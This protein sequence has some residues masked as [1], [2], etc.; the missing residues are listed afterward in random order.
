MADDLKLYLFGDQTYDIQP[1]LKDL[2]RHR[3]NPVLEDFLAKAYDAVRA[4][5]Y[6]LPVQVRD[7]LPRFTCM[8]DLVLWNQ[9]GRRCVPLD[10]AVT[11]MYQ[12][13]HFINQANDVS[14]AA[15]KSR[16]AGLC[17]GALAA[18]AVSCSRNILDL[19]PMAVDAVTVAFRVGMHVTD[20]ALRVAPLSETD[21]SWSIIVP[22]ASSHEAVHKFS[23][24]SILP[25]TSK[26]YVSAYAPN[27]I[28]V[29]GPP[30]TLA[31]LVKSESFKDLRSKSI[32]IYAPYHAPHL[33]SSS[34]PAEI[35][36]DLT[37][38][39]TSE[40]SEKIPLIS[41]TGSTIE[42]RNFPKLLEEAVAQILLRP[43]KWSDI[44]N[45]LQ[46]SIK[47]LNP[48]SLNVVPIATTAD[49]LIYTAL[50]QSSLKSV[51]P[52]AP[53]P[54]KSASL[55]EASFDS[56]KKPRLAIIGMSG[57]YPGAKDDDAFWDLLYQGLDVHKP[58]PA[59]HWDVKTHVDPTGQRKNT[60]QTPYGCWLDDPAVF[61]AR[62]FNI[63]PREAPQIDPAQ[64][65][66]LMTAYEAIE[67]A[68]I[69]PDA[70]P[71]TR[72]DR[73]GVFYGVTSN[74]WM[75]TNSAQNIDTYFIPGGNRAF[76]PGRINY[77]FKFSGP[78]YAVD[79]ACSS[80]LAGIHLA[81][82]S[83]W[84]GD[85]D[86]AIAGGTNVL[87]NPDFTSGL[88]RG[89]FLSRTGNCQTFDDAADGYCRGE[90]I[91][92]VIIKRYE[93]AV[94]DK[95][96]IL[97][98]VLGAYT[99]HS[100]ESESITRPHVGAQRAIFNKILNQ[101][102]VD[103]YTVSYVEMHG[104]GTQAG[105]AGEMSSVLDT[106]A[107]PLSQVKRARNS[108]ENLYLGSAKANIGH[109]EAASGV[110]SL[111]KVLLMMKKNMIVPHCG[112]KTKINHRFPTDLGERNVNIALKPTP[113]ER[114][115]DPAKP[116]RVFV[117]N[118]SAAGGNS[119]LLLEDAPL[120]REPA[121]GEVDLRDQHL[122]AVSAKNGPSLQG[123][124]RNLRDFLKGNPSISIGQL[125]Y[126]TTARR[127][128]HQHRVMLTGTSADDICG[129]IDKALK[130]NTGMTRPKSAPK[131][132]FTFTG[133]GAQ[134]PGMGKQLYDN[135]STFRK[136]MR[137][138]DQIAQSLGFPSMLPVI[139][140]EE[141]DI[142]IFAPTA[143]QLASV[144]LQIA[145]SKMWASWNVHPI[146][147]IGHS[148]GE[149]AALNT[150]GVLSDA[151]TVY[152]VG[153][154]ASLL[155]EKCT[156]DT[157]AMLV[158][159]GSVDEI[160]T[161]LKN[162]K[163][164]LVCMN[165]PVETVLGGSNEEVSAVKTVLTEAGM[166]TILLSVPYAFHSSQMDPMLSEFTKRASGVTFSD[167]KIPILRPI[168]GE[169]ITEGGNFGPEY[170]ASH[171]RSPVNMQ[172]ALHTARNKN[173]ITDQTAMLELGPHPAISGMVKAVLGSQ[174][175]NLASSQRGR[176]AWKVLG[177]TLKTLYSGG[178]DVA[179]R[180]YHRDFTASHKVVQLPAY[181][182]DLKEFWM[183]YVNDW[184][185]RKGDP[186]LMIEGKSKLE[187]TTIHKVVEETGDAKKTKIV[188][189]AD[190]ARKDLSPLVQGHE[191][192]GIPLCTPSV[193]ADMALTL[194][195]YL[196]NKYHPGQKQ[197]IV[198]ITD[199]TI[200]KALILQAGASQQLLQ[201]H[202]EVDW[203]SQSASVKFCSF[204][205]SYFPARMSR[206]EGNLILTEQQSK[207]KLQ[208][209]SRCVLR[210]KDN[211][212]LSKLQGEVAN[213]K[214]KVQG[215]RDGIVS[216]ATARFNRPMV[217]RAIRPLA[218]FH[219][220]Y[221]AIDEILL[222]SNTLEAVSK[223]SYGTVKRGGNYHTHP[224][225]IDSLTQSCGFTMNCNDS[226]DLD[227]EV[228][229]NHGWGSFQLFEPIDF[230]KA[231]TTYT[232]M[233]EGEDKLW[234]GDVVVLDGDKVVAFFGQIAI[235]GVPR[236]VLKVILSI[237]A[238]NKGGAK[239]ASAPKQ[240][241]TQKPAA[242]PAAAAKA[243][244]LAPPS[245]AP[246]SSSGPKVEKAME[247]I[248]DESGL[249]PADLTDGTNFGD[250]GIDS[251]LGLTISARFKEDLDMDLDFNAL[252]YEYPTVG[253]L[254]G[255]LG[256]SKVSATALST[257]ETAGT[258]AT[259][260]RSS[261]TD[262]TVPEPNEQP[263]DSS[264]SKAQ[265]QRAL[266][267]I[268]EESGVA[269]ED[270][271]D[272]TNFADSGV[273]SLLS[274][275]VVSRLRDELEL[276]IPH[277]S[278]FLECPTVA[279]LKQAL[280]PGADASAAAPP[281]STSEPTPAPTAE[282]A[283]KGIPKL[284]EAETAALVTRKKAVDE[285]VAK[286]TAGWVAP[287]PSP[288]AAAPS[289][290]EKVVLVTGA[291][292]SLGGH[293]VDHI[294]KLTD[295]KTVVCLN[296]ENRA[297]PAVR[298]QKAMR[299][300]GLRSFD[301]LKSKLHILQTD[302]AK[303]R[304]GLTQADYDKLAGSVTHI[305]H[306][307]WPMSAKRALAGFESQFAVMRNLLDFASSAAAKRPASFR[308]SF[309]MV[310]S[311]GVVG[312]YG[313]GNGQDRTMV[314]EERMPIDTV[315]ANGYGEAKW[316]CERMLDETLHQHHDRF[317]TMTV[318]LGQIA[319]SKTS[320][321]WNPME[322][323]GFLVKSSQTLNALPDV[324]GKVYWT[325]VNDIA[326]TLSDLVLA[327]NEP[328]AFYHIEN[329][330]GQS[331]KEMNAVLA[332]ALNIP[333]LIPFEEWTARVKNAP[334]KNNPA[335]T[336]LE[337]LDSNYLRMSCGGLVL[338]VKNALEHSATLRSIGPLPDVIP[339]K[340]IQIWKE[341]GFL[342][343]SEEEK[344]NLPKIRN[345]L[346][347]AGEAVVG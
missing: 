345:E 165:S 196:I 142:G 166:K 127:Q 62:F 268:S 237:E 301:S 194:G 141:Q 260:P 161:I 222:N 2:L 93:D 107:P 204:D 98:L 342:S 249:A 279:D 35:I 247:I 296:R 253:D 112:I 280:F 287:T 205:V 135:F 15:D 330:V 227:N 183:Q 212:L 3:H 238:G 200:F 155:E 168:D 226:T 92:T 133:Q 284:S 118:F 116:R 126:T 117:N 326:A 191:V 170:L 138:L 72:R 95:D 254:K 105:D 193:Y 34:D 192:D 208:E 291:S 151:D 66:A 111:V 273:D 14:Y 312:H 51:V 32:S 44:L 175:S 207:Q 106:F 140:S 322:H 169:L 344:K 225:I 190:I 104:T 283:N 96:P 282:L 94:A 21:Q 123:N 57:R 89:H 56:P 246:A 46:N 230:D 52:P 310:S 85:I 184:S 178:S 341:I 313:L 91:G 220:D 157:H 90:G 263:V 336:L 146:A 232:R 67:Q 321:Y 173:I 181:S 218:R 55:P 41:S 337:F 37:F 256:D 223:L 251:L 154:R 76:I 74:D 288:S 78:S 277:E 327:D 306:Q 83:L 228:F 290:K 5:I 214:K 187:S 224:A 229:M 334:S 43:I 84:R 272:D 297:D 308:F 303:P 265:F 16:T 201:A 189:E 11:C 318:R 125:S 86:T 54:P 160:S 209:H 109:G 42:G 77:C 197:D 156:R 4:E 340:Y 129:Q 101:G 234:K 81:C 48:K 195:K 316:G 23:A 103:P 292:G 27:G 185:L 131:V 250:V 221:R 8:D 267:I 82:N 53:S 28:T 271:T 244:T 252:F 198:D 300:K 311:I 12:L 343:M 293:L 158:V 17:T 182:W 29:S 121:A 148:L 130:D 233:S 73:V 179:W 346:W 75:E 13:G 136:E 45:E 289:D 176:S 266:E 245:S 231:Y 331:W 329:P 30:E 219:D 153:M 339:R 332:S 211:S 22:G 216:G 102:A 144:C 281:P 294:A 47:K 270:L 60:S 69:V 9:S 307:A 113:W 242:A 213:T 18:A 217:Y 63:S 97:G 152:L 335:A 58:A 147:V 10:M 324:P 199:M 31:T 119:A 108:E 235:Q 275:V 203:S 1:Y 299:E 137:R 240:Q 255:F 80:S 210:F 39:E 40:R 150:S 25:S 88:D 167:P 33:H 314:P 295:V 180:E 65:L 61:D 128:H 172:K 114:S 19:V 49:Q 145:L 286:Y 163:F 120:E 70:T 285:L 259:S 186:P 132:V 325:P 347:G 139:Q 333:H 315:L 26:P 171:S 50:K 264:E 99:N 122:I 323:F 36:G 110:S 309:Q 261:A 274:L 236:K 6:N 319:G 338:D 317:R 68:G 269:L 174:I 243:P 278:L 302:S 328:H 215:L 124:M 298:Q 206:V 202:A 24:S 258:E 20:V 38:G 79:T 164:E 239:Q 159:K 188:V 305:I 257:P 149:Y 64:R 7:D 115:S 262:I 100:A 143:V 248:A 304:F 59:L 71:S 320:G 134:Y 162:K 276:D 241:P 87:T 177:E